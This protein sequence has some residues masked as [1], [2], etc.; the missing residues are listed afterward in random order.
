MVK[1]CELDIEY[2]F[3][4]ASKDYANN[5]VYQSKGDGIV[6]VLCRKCSS[7]DTAKRVVEIVLGC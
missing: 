5:V 2:C 7:R 4:C 1:F 3:E 6:V